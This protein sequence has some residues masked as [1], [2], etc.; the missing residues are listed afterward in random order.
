LRKHG[1]QLSFKREADRQGVEADVAIFYGLWGT[2]RDAVKE[3]P[4]A[5]AKT[6][7]CD[8]GFFGRLDGGK[9]AGYH[10]IA[11]NGYHATEYFQRVRHTPERFRHHGIKPKPF[12]RW[13]AYV[14]MTGMS[15]KAAWVY[16][17]DAE[18]WERET[19]RSLAQ[20]SSRPVMYRPK[21]S[22]KDASPIPGTLWGGDRGE[23]GKEIDEAL[24]GAWALVTHHGNTAVDALVA[25]VPVFTKAGIASV[26]AEPDLSN[27]ERPR[28]PDEVE[29]DQL[30]YDAAWTQWKPEEIAEG[31]AWTYLL[32]EGLV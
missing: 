10:R 7:F 21:P 5:G 11:V 13:G 16:G 30:L 4:A 18:Q 20:S 31:K 29:R 32:E 24:A 2:L 3:Y 28:F 19:A 27:I 9:V 23:E 17:L 22:W 1:L 6:V 15:S 25:G 8:L 26:L 14:L 12:R